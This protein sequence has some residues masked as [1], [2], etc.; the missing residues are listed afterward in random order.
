[1][2]NVAYGELAKQ[3]LKHQNLRDKFNKIDIEPGLA[4]FEALQLYLCKLVGVV[5][6]HALLSRA[7]SQGKIRVSS[8][9]VLRIKADGKLEGIEKIFLG[10]RTGALEVLLGHL[11][12]LLVTFVGEGLTFQLLRDVWPDMP[13]EHLNLKKE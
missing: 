13:L 4:A 1:M 3:L 12:G 9:S 10:E 7:L 6:F 5:G 11:L 8:L 2:G